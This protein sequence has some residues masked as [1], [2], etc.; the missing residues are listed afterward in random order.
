MSRACRNIILMGDQMQLGQPIQGTHPGESGLSI[1]DYLLEDQ[2]TIAP[3]MGVFLPMTYR[4]HPAVCDVISRQ[5]YD[6]KLSSHITTHKH[7]VQVKGPL[8]KNGSGV[9]FIPV[10]HE[11]NTQGSP[12]EV[13]SIASIVKE[14][15]GLSL[16]HI[17]EPTR[18]Y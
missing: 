18:P 7:V 1:L 14:L 12:E 10:E 4:M 5:V 3:E 6:G 2:S 9:I 15:L 8:V 11:G 16:I 13:D 17:S